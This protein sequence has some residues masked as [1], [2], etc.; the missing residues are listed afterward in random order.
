MES[1]AILALV[2]VLL[3][4]YSRAA[5]NPIDHSFA[6]RKRRMF[7]WLPLGLSYAFLYMG[8]YNLTV[9]KNALKHRMTK[10]QF[11]T[12]FG[13]GT[14][15]YAHS[16]IINGPLTDRIGGKRAMIIAVFGAALG[17]IALGYI[18]R[19]ALTNP[20]ATT[21]LTLLY[22]L[23]YAFNMYFQSYGAVAIVKVNSNW[24]HVRERGSFGGMFGVLIS[25][26]IYFAFDWGKA[27]VEACK[28]KPAALTFFQE[29]I[30]GA[31]KPTGDEIWWV[32]YLPAG[33]L[34][35]FGIIDIVVLRERPGLA[36]FE[37]FDTADASSGEEND[38]F[39]LS[40]VLK[41]IFSSKVMWTIMLIEFCSGV[42]RNGVMH[43][44]PIY[45]TETKAPKSFLFKGHWGKVL[46]VA[47]ITGGM[48]AGFVSDKVFGSRRGPVAALLYAVL[49]VSTLAAMMV[50]GTR[51]PLGIVMALMSLSVI[52]VHGM[53]SGTASMDFGGRRAA[54]TAVGVIDGF[55]YLGTGLQAFALGRLTTQSWSY[56]APFMAPFAVIGLVLAIKI[57][58]AFPDS[59]R[60]GA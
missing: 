43:W 1:I 48:A 20:D 4:V 16:F 56:W 25:L 19:D 44:Y 29:L 17:N 32:F 14:V 60:K 13:A 46:A 35:L 57:W 31:V 36:G 50:L 54:G 18:T 58:R 2:A 27:I 51:Y 52:G 23:A 26:G 41:K 6:Y 34:L 38:K 15:T 21:N 42:L 28:A 9:A 10:R 45:L 30:R 40:A 11:G 12:I 59:K 47:G 7:N 39:E 3:A 55:V 53:L 22:A 49:L 5:G 24:F 8:R 37:D 33:L